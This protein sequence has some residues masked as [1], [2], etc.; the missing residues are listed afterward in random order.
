MLKNNLQGGSILI[1]TLLML[2]FLQFVAITLVNSTNISSLVVR[3]FQNSMQL[4]KS[5]NKV[6]NHVLKNKDYFTNY[7]IYLNKAGD[8]N[9]PLNSLLIPETNA[10]IISFKC[11]DTVASKGIL[12]CDLSDKYWQLIVQ[13]EDLNTKATMQIV[14]GIS[15]SLLP[16]NSIDGAASGPQRVLIKTVWWY[17]L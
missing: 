7:S 16:Q 3:N 17:Q 6:I 11:I 4:K 13:V 15:L 10:K 5:A 2:L 12:N 1:L 8:F 14:Q 9:I